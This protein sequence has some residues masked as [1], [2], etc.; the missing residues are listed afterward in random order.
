M[1]NM[2]INSFYIPVLSLMTVIFLL[3]SCGKDREIQFCEGVSPDGK[4]INCGTVF[5]YGDIT[6]IIESRER[7]ATDQIKVKIE[8]IRNESEISVET[9]E[10]LVEPDEREAIV[11]LPLYQSGTYRITALR[12]ETELA[13][14]KVEIAD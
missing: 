5:E 14:D 10:A 1:L 2:K 9:I 8:I 6:A 4:G 3:T 13:K 11:N 12:G 7:F